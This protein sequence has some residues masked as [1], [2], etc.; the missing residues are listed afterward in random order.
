MLHFLVRL[1]YDATVRFAPNLLLLLYLL[2]SI[3][4]LDSTAIAT[5]ASYDYSSLPPLLCYFIKFVAQVLTALRKIA[6]VAARLELS[7]WPF[8]SFHTPSPHGQ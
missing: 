6:G 1:A 2:R 8:L 7:P 3:L 5:Y 4:R